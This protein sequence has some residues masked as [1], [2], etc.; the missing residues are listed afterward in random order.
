[1]VLDM[2]EIAKSGDIV[3]LQFLIMLENQRRTGDV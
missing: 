1:M 3:Y 2:S